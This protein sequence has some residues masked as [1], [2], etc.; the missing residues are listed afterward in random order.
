MVE[1]LLN[2][3]LVLDKKRWPLL[4]NQIEKKW[5]RELEQEVV[6]TKPVLFENKYFIAWIMTRS[7]LN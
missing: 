6:L 4:R 7:S 2:K 5:K 1:I 3:S